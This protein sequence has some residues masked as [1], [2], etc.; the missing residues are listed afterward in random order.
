MTFIA[1][2]AR[3]ADAGRRAPGPGAAF[4]AFALTA[5]VSFMPT[6]E[7]M[8]RTWATA[9][10]YHHGFLIAPLVLWLIWR[11][12]R[13]VR[14]DEAR[15]SSPIRPAPDAAANCNRGALA[16][17]AVSCALWLAGRALSANIIE[18]IAFVSLLIAGAVLAFG[19]GWAKARAF[20]L[21]MLYFMVPFGT[22]LAPTLQAAAAGVVT[23]CLDFAGVETARDGLILSTATGRFEIA[24]GCAG[25]NFLLASLIIASVYGALSLRGWKKRLVLVAALGALAV[26]ANFLRIFLVIALT[27]WS[28]GRIELAADHLLFGWALY[29]VLLVPALLAAR[30]FADAAPTPCAAPVAASSRKPLAFAIA[31]V[32]AAAAI[33][34]LPAPLAPSP[35]SG[36]LEKPAA[37]PPNSLPPLAAREGERRPAVF[38]QTGAA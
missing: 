19:P 31:A 6:V 11:E 30:R 7:T 27:E 20:P 34:R 8:V 15:R 17:V 36:R 37:L 12:E 33:E 16:A 26:L 25:L 4:A 5:L 22:S 10:A 9:G 14:G 18:Q 21:A 28:G 24:E 35:V 32:V 23:S 38:P 2:E 13:E 1:S 29:G 3:D